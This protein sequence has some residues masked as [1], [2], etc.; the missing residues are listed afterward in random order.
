MQLILDPTVLLKMI[1]LSQQHGRIIFKIVLFLFRTFCYKIQLK[2]FEILRIDM[3]T[4][5]RPVVCPS[6]L[7][8]PP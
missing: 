6:N 5:T 2:P 7:S 3:S 8:Q 4:Q 1:L